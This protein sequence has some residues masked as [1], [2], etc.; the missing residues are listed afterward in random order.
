MSEWIILI[1]LWLSCSWGCSSLLAPR[2]AWRSPR[3]DAFSGLVFLASWLAN[4][5]DIFTSGALASA[6]SASAM[7]WFVGILVVGGGYVVTIWVF[8]KVRVWVYGCGYE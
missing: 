8:V 6:A 5:I 7:D 4:T 1:I 3:L 2:Q